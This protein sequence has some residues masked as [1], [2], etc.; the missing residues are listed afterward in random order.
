M[1]RNL[2]SF[3]VK[4]LLRVAGWLLMIEGAFMLVPLVTALIYRESDWLPFAV[5]AALTEVIGYALNHFIQPTHSDMGRREGFLLTASAWVVF[6]LFGM[7]PFIF[8]ATPQT[9]SVAFFEA[10]SGF[11]T[12]GATA[13]PDTVTYSHAVNMWRAVMQWI[14]GLGIILFTL[15]V[16]PM[17]NYTGGMQLF[18]AE[19]TGITHDKIQPRVSQTAMTLWGMYI[20]LTAACAVLLALGPMDTFSAVCHAFSTLSTGGFSCAAPGEDV[21]APAYTRLVVTAFMAL[22]GINF[23][24]IYR[25]LHGH[26][27][28]VAKNNIFRLYLRIIV[29]CTAVFFVATLILQTES[30]WVNAL[31]NSAFRVVSTITST[32]FTLGD[33]WAAGSFG[34]CIMIVLLYFGG[35]AGSTSGGAKL[36]RAIVMG[37]FAANETRRALRPNNIL[38]VKVGNSVLTI[39][40]V[41]KTIAFLIIFAAVIFFGGLVLTAM[42]IPMADALVSSLSAITNGYG[43]LSQGL[44]ASLYSMPAAGLWVLALIMLIGRLEVFTII[45]LLL[46]SFWRR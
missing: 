18:N 42:G 46:P 43:I 8:C 27:R 13:M 30:G 10:M 5:A 35:C 25:A 3:N 26:F 38:A 17:L 39:E 44:G 37:K 16:L 21:F 20:A 29:L 14:G 11:T 22:G 32:G 2:R 24:L 45:V 34:F 31:I 9:V 40:T 28:D 15:A 12:T 6:S 33:P 1:R 36:D 7:L 23:V 19:V 41:Q 4:M